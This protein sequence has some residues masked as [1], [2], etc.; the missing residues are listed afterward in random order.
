M[1]VVGDRLCFYTSDGVND[2]SL[3]V[4]SAWTLADAFVFSI[5]SPLRPSSMARYDDDRGIMLF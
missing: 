1:R 2:G 4:K 3:L 5:L